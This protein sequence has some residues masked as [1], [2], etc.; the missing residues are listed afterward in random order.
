MDQRPKCKNKTIKLLEENKEQN[1]PDIGLGSSFLDM[2][3][4]IQASK[5]KLGM[6]IRIKDFKIKKIK[7]LKIK[8]ING[9]TSN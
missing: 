8:K 1:I 9:T 2:T 5:A 3:Q 4:T 6:P 7:K